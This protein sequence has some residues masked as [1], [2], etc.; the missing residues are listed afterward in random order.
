M[1]ICDLNISRSRLC[2]LKT[3]S[4]LVIYSKAVL[5]KAIT[6]KF[7]QPI[8]WGYLKI[9]EFSSCIKKVKFLG[10]RLPGL[11]RADLAGSFCVFFR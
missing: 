6:C 2:P 11:L 7:L 4:I 3:N 1:I 5:S 8:A 9:S 10:C